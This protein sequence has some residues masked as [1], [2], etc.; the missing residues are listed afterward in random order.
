MLFRSLRSDGVEQVLT[1]FRRHDR[2]GL[3]QGLLGGRPVFLQHRLGQGVELR[4][5]GE[6]FEDDAWRPATVRVATT[7]PQ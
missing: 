5:R 6:E 3:R 4:L 2:G 7:T 1:F